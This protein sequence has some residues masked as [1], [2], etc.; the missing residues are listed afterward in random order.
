MKSVQRDFL[1]EIWTAPG[2]NLEAL[3]RALGRSQTTEADR[4][5]LGTLEKNGWIRREGK[6]LF[7]RRFFIT[8]E[9]QQALDKAYKSK[10]PVRQLK[11]PGKCER[12]KKKTGDLISF[13]GEELC[14][15]CLT[16]GYVV[17][18][19]TLVRSNCVLI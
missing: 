6:K 2:S 5:V 14:G 19:P 9:G 4:Q 1:V 13:Q 3:R 18:R 11:K 10:V 7:D 8:E 15:D 17:T 16:D 12:C